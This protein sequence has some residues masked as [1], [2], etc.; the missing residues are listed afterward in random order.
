MPRLRET[1]KWYKRA[2]RAEQRLVMLE[3]ALR[4]E[5]ER[6]MILQAAVAIASGVH[7][8]HC[9]VARHERAMALWQAQLSHNFPDGD[10]EN[11]LQEIM[12]VVRPS[13]QRGTNSF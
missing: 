11:A 1:D 12:Q 4:L 8:E 3:E 6:R 7:C 2:R 5:R 10:R 9:A 13:I